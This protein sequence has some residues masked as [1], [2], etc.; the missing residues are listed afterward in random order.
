M[1]WKIVLLIGGAIA[2]GV[3]YALKVIEV[4]RLKDMNFLLN[5]D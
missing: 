1:I 4:N 5:D 2:L 3:L